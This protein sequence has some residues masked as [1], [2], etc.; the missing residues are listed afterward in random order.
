[1]HCVQLSD[2]VDVI[3]GDAW[4][5]NEQAIIDFGA[6]EPVYTPATVC[7]NRTQCTLTPTTEYT[8]P[9]GACCM[10]TVKK[11]MHLLVAPLFGC[12]PAFLVAVKE[13]NADSGSYT[14][15]PNDPKDHEHV[16]KL[17]Q[18]LNHM[19]TSLNLQWSENM[20]P[21]HQNVFGYIRT[22]KHP[23]VQRS[24]YPSP[25]GQEVEKQVR[26]LLE[27]GRIVPFRSS[28][29]EPV[30]FVPKPDECF[31]MCIDYRELKLTDSHTRV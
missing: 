6:V 21:P 30:L 18:L 31:R 7:L 2:E 3:L 8:S 19:S 1:V 24:A 4:L 22:V 13:S 5:R 28:Y 29:G 23:F 15:Q 27:T 20:T 10:I 14:Q 12:K 16:D 26:E 11:A 25:E 17:T 9:P